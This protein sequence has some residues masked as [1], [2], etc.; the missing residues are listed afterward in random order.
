ML[1]KRIKKGDM[2][3]RICLL[4]NRTSQDK[5]IKRR[6]LHKCPVTFNFINGIIFRMPCRD[7][8]F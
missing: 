6:K 7:Y 2:I 1:L 8:H 5:H 4:C 3:I